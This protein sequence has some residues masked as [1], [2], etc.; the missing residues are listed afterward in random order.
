M[1]S[2]DM[3]NC[4]ILINTTLAI[5]FIEQ[6][7]EEKSVHIPPWQKSDFIVLLHIVLDECNYFLYDGQFYRQI[8]GIFMANSLGSIIVQIVTEHFI[9]KVLDDLKKKRVILSILYVDDHLVICR[10][11]AIPIILRPLSEFD[12]GRIKRIGRSLSI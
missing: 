1:A 7:F 9:N 6:D 10:E 12:P 5:D 2:F 3:V 4:F 11:E 8:N